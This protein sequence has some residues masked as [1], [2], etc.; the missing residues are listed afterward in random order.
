[1]RVMGVPEGKVELHVGSHTMPD[2]ELVTVP[3]PVGDTA[4]ESI[5]FVVEVSHGPNV[6]VPV[7]P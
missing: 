7:L 2:G 5:G 6:I 1:M 3:P 4:T